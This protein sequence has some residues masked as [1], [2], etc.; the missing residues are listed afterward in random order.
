MKKMKGQE[1]LR[2]TC[3]I[4]LRKIVESLF[5]KHPPKREILIAGDAEPFTPVSEEEVRSYAKK[6]G[7]RKTPGPD[8]IPNAALKQ[9]MEEKPEVFAET[10]NKYLQRGTFP[11]NWKIQ[12]LILLP[13]GNKLT[14]DPSGYRPICLLDT[15]GKVL[16]MTIATRISKAIEKKGALSG[17]QYGF[18]KARSTIDAIKALPEGCKLI[19]FADD[20]A[21]LVVA[22]E[23]KEVE[24]KANNAIKCISAW[25]AD[26]GQDLA[27]H[28]TEAVLFTSRKKVEHITIQVGNCPIRSKGAIKY[29]RVMLDNRLSYGAHVD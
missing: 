18:R 26:S 20:L 10:F 19:G 16:E 27:V 9:A 5:P 17:N 15:V 21:L 14:D 11:K 28:K 1:Y 7:A 25:M 6:I 13:K 12:N 29:L 23:T 8:G 3:P 2:P 22:K 24:T 4:L